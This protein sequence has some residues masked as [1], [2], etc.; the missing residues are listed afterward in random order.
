MEYGF[1][2][3]G[4]VRPSMGELKQVIIENLQKKLGVE[5]YTGPGSVVL[6][7]IDTASELFAANFEAA[8]GASQNMYPSTAVG[9]MLDKAISFTAVRRI[10]KAK[11]TGSVMIK[12]NFI[13]TTGTLPT[14]FTVKT[15][16]GSSEWKT[17]A[18]YK[19][20]NG[21]LYAVD[22]S[23]KEG[24]IKEGNQ[25]SFT[26]GTDI[27]V[28]TSFDKNPAD[29][30][31]LQLITDLYENNRIN[32]KNN[33]Y[34]IENKNDYLHIVF[35]VSNNGIIKIN[36]NF[37]GVVCHTGITFICSEYGYIEAAKGVI[38]TVDTKVQGLDIIGCENLSDMIPGHSGESHADL[39]DR[40]RQGAPYINGGSTKPALQQLMLQNVSGVRACKI[41][42][43][44]DDK[45]DSMNRPAHTL[46]VVVEGGEDTD[47]AEMLY[48]SCQAGTQY[49]GTSEVQMGDGNSVKFD[50]PKPVYLWVKVHVDPIESGE[51]KMARNIVSTIPETLSEY[52][53]LIHEIGTDI[54][55]G[56]LR[57]H[58]YSLSGVGYADV[59]I[60]TTQDPKVS[61]KDE[62]Y[63][64][65]NITIPDNCIATFDADRIIV[66]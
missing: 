15:S 1:T 41:F 14:G 36:T 43:N 54:I 42:D 26:L 20:G 23:L 55:V 19:I 7:Y 24:A 11:G 53:A 9:P 58:I 5:L 8:E 64:T 48:N 59:S 25:I 37:F 34:T 28:K 33:G 50:R 60:A 57:S 10:P 35:P 30:T 6:Q 39:R 61:P 65:K 44:P 27:V 31:T 2:S 38:D 13:D 45:T 52:A 12:Y 29:L 62:E 56:K 63:I 51:V 3:T 49:F 66:I 32:L 22:V 40:Y 16:N 17:N 18:P 21:K 46:H 47:I 4:F